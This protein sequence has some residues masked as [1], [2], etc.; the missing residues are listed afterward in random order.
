M[1]HLR[2]APIFAARLLFSS[3]VFCVSVYLTPEA[4]V[5]RG[6]AS[7][8]AQA[9]QNVARDIPVQIVRIPNTPI[10]SI[11]IANENYIINLATR[12]FCTA[13]VVSE[14]FH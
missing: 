5:V 9:V 4:I 3:G 13:S 1:T 6:K 11:L 2:S 10:L 8:Q 12:K 7:V 14:G